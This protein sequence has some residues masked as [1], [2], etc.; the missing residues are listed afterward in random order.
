[1]RFS[2]NTYVLL[3][4]PPGEAALNC[5][6]LNVQA[7]R[8]TFAVLDITGDKGKER[9]ESMSD[10]ATDTVPDEGTDTVPQQEK[11]NDDGAKGV[12]G[13]IAGEGGGVENGIA[14]LRMS[15]D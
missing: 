9:G 15:S 10:A 12:D 7:A 6:R 13:G 11:D 8:N 1:M 14:A 3:V 2:S 4:F 5:T